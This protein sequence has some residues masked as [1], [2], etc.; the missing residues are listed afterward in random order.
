MDAA[1]EI[2]ASHLPMEMNGLKF[3]TRDGGYSGDDIREILS[4]ASSKQWLKDDF[5]ASP[6][7]LNNMETYCEGL[8]EMI[9][10]GVFNPNLKEEIVKNREV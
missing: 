7:K 1:I 10:K 6:K 3:F 4:R 2:T 5:K 8:R 9:K